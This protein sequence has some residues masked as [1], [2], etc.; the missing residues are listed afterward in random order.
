M[1]IKKAFARIMIVVA[2]VGAHAP[3]VF[4]AEQLNLIPWPKS[5]DA[6]GGRMQVTEQSRIV[7]SDKSLAS[8]GDIL[9]ED[10]WRL[11]A[12]RLKVTEGKAGPGDLAI[13][14]SPGLKAEAYTV[15]I[16]DRALIKG[17]TYQA[18][19]WGEVTLVQ[20]LKN[21]DKVSL[22]RVGIRD[23]PDTEYRGTMID[24]ARRW[25][26]VQTVKDSIELARLY[27][28][29][30]LHLHL[31]DNQLFV[32]PSKSFPELASRN[33][34]YTLDEM[35]DIVR[36]ADERGVTLIP[37]IDVPGHAGS[38]IGKRADIFG[39]TDPATGESKST[40]VVNM[41]SEKAYEG[42]DALVGDLCDMFKSSPYIHLGTDET[43][44]DGLKKLPEY[45]VYTEKHGLKEAAEGHA[46][47]LF[48]H[49]IARMDEIVKK[50]GRQMIVWG[51]PGST[52][53]VKAPTDAIDMEWDGDP[54]A[55]LKKG[56]KVIN[57]S[58]SSLYIVPPQGGAPTP[59][60]L[61]AWNARLVHINS[62][63]GPTQI[64]ATEKNLIG[65]QLCFW[66]QRYNEV[67]PI[68]R[69]RISAMSER[70]W[71]VE[72]GKSFAD[73]ETRFKE[74]DRSVGKILFPVAIEAAGLI[75]PNDVRFTDKLT[76][77]LT[78]T[79]PGTI[80]Y[81]L[82]KPWETFPT[83]KS[84]AFS[85]P[86]VLDDTMTVSARLY[87]A[88]GKPVGGFTQER[89]SK[90]VV[91]YKYRLM[92]PTPGGSWKQMPDFSKLTELRTG[93]MG[94]MTTDRTEQI[95]RSMWAGLPA[96]GH[97]EVRIPGLWNARTLEL[98]GKL[99]IPADG[100]YQF[101]VRTAT[102]QA[103]LI[104]GEGILGAC[105]EPSKDNIT[106]SKLKAGTYPFT[107]K[108]YNKGVFNDLNIQ[109]KGPTDTQFVPFE[110]LNLAL[111]SRSA[112][113][114]PRRLLVNEPFDYPP[115]VYPPGNWEG[116][117]GS[118]IGWGKNG[119]S[120]HTKTACNFVI[121]AAGPAGSY[122]E[123]QGQNNPGS[124]WRDRAMSP[125]IHSNDPGTVTWQSML[126][127][128]DGS[129]NGG[130]LVVHNTNGG[131]DY[132]I[133]LTKENTY[134]LLGGHN[135][136]QGT[137]QEALSTRVASTDPKKPDFLLLKITNLDDS[138]MQSVAL[139]I[140]PDITLDETKLPKPD[141][142][143]SYQ[144]YTNNRSIGGIIL[145]PGA[146][147][148]DEIVF[149]ETCKDVILAIPPVPPYAP[150][151]ADRA[152]DV[153]VT[154]SLRWS[155]A[156]ADSYKV[157]FWNN[158]EKKPDEPSATVLE[159]KFDLPSKLKLNTVYSWQVIVVKGN[160]EAAGPRW[161][162]KTGGPLPPGPVSK[163]IPAS[164][165]AEALTTPTLRWD[166]AL[167]ATSYNVYL[168]PAN[169]EKPEKP[170]ANVEVES[171]TPSTALA[172]G[173]A[174]RWQIE[175]ANDYGKD[176]KAPVWGFTTELLVNTPVPASGSSTMLAWTPLE[177]AAAPEA[178]SYDIYLW[179][180]GTN[181]PSAPTGTVTTNRY[182][183][184]K[185]LNFSTSYHWRVVARLKTGGTV[186]G[187]QWSFTTQAD[188]KTVATPP[189]DI[190]PSAQA[191][192]A[193]L[194]DSH[195]RANLCGKNTPLKKDM[196]IAFYGDSI[197]WLG[198]YTGVIEKALKTGE[199]SKDLAVKIINHGVNGGGVLT[200]RDG[201]DSKSHFGNTK[202]RPFAE[203]IAEDKPDV[204]VVFIGVND[205]WWRKTSPTDFEKALTNLVAT[206]KANHARMVLA[207]LSVWGDSPVQDQPNNVKCDQYSEIVRKVAAANGVALADLRK[208]CTAY[209]M[210]HNIG[211]Q[212]D[213]SLK[214]L[215]NSILTG[216][217]VHPI[218][219]GNELLADVLSQGIFDALTKP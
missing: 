140:N 175:A 161:T 166:E 203:T 98:S 218:S 206:T 107:I 126:M 171:Y 38:W 180:D 27:K 40:G 87:D 48:S 69:P 55:G 162:F 179:K 219:R 158:A 92:G 160:V 63:G 155:N 24:L 106:T 208:A 13:Q 211:F 46:H 43:S 21:D 176:T 2:L 99:R 23:Q 204:V 80:R 173:T 76:V 73:F 184:S 37:E 96:F 207:T 74:V 124:E 164:P 209:L 31:S 141:L 36:F 81:T 217:G 85:A 143:V 187:P 152:T 150:I 148:M 172:F 51:A 112:T 108:Y 136:T 16:T 114:R 117:S 186:A 26:P 120:D 29:R 177:W 54:V 49:F 159:P 149:G 102:G 34:S 194:Y 60:S 86:I 121:G 11:T 132:H 193:P 197:T 53:K 17:G 113:A 182:F 82:S 122:F 33:E 190:S 130:G 196:K 1:N 78:T 70:L 129:K 35:T 134:Q 105:T 66:E 200:L 3:A 205:I 90:I 91:G 97:I 188:G 123:S 147:K 116:L 128:S 47:E 135:N 103:E 94:L 77:K 62:S 25:H 22:P 169:Q 67:I 191:A 44:A 71:N 6:L 45:K 198:G 8:L 174:Y 131:T 4:A 154:K 65:A 88:A 75:E 199:G 52:A 133:R 213:G 72:A 216:D 41:A 42:M 210:N 95:N 167:R 93:V 12:L 118:G 10:I 183:P 101:K 142:S 185:Y 157:F 127:W 214:L 145:S 151:P 83:A 28:I 215:D 57:A 111:S 146:V 89:Y 30:Y 64:P 84:D 178:E 56:F 170:T 58:Q 7:I 14:L 39:T 20:L 202:P 138:G 61:Y 109:V 201:E 137:T 144:A 32:F 119:Y 79:L 59:E 125:A 9:S 165:S 153:S 212:R 189:F 110:T 115:R 19:A 5:V 168:W 50:H 104:S 163:P 139:W 195:G 156:D 68:L 192:R 18:C 181:R 100:D 15:G